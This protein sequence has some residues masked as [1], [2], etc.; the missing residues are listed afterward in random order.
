MQ[1]VLKKY[2]E[3]KRDKKDKRYERYEKIG[4]NKKIYKKDKI[5]KK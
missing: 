4:R 1:A 3:I 5:K 2:K